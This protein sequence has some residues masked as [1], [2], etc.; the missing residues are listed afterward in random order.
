LVQSMFRGIAESLK[1]GGLFAQY[2]PFNYGGQYTS[3]SNARFDIWL[4]NRDPESAIRNFEDLQALALSH[5]MQLFADYA[6][7]ANNRTL[8]WRKT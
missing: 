6:M 2:G 4:K 7:P 5:G 8:I 3:E 1:P